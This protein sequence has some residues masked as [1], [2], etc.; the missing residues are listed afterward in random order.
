M[1]HPLQ[2]WK[3][4]LLF[5]WVGFVCAISFMEAW[6]KFTAPGVSL[7]TG[8][9]IGR[10]V[11]GALNK[12]ELLLAT[13]V[14]LIILKNRATTLLAEGFFL[15]SVAI[16]LVQTFLLLPFL[17]SRI[18]IYLSGATP[19]PSRM[20]AVYVALELLKVLSLTIYGFNNLRIWKH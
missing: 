1:K 17:S 12:V 19:Q 2:P 9:S 20:H 13:V 10:V 5:I 8:L 6:L 14:G 4:A 7:V 15:L 3:I 11:F 16:L 18:D